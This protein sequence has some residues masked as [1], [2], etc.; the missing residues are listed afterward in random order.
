[1]ATSTSVPAT[2]RADEFVCEMTIE[3]KAMQ[4]PSVVPLAGISVERPH[5]DAA[6]ARSVRESDPGRAEAPVGARPLRVW[7][8]IRS[9]LTDF[10][11]G[12]S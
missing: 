12:H 11:T 7:S 4:L 10:L 8:R 6:A 3:E 1:M 5:P 2:E 9:D